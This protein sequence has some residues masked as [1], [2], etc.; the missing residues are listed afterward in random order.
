MHVTVIR[1]SL[2]VAQPQNITQKV[3]TCAQHSNTGTVSQAS[4]L[5]TT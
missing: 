1:K 4:C 3:S 2:S 5:F